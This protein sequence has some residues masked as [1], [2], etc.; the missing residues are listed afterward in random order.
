[1][2]QITSL[3]LFVTQ[4][5]MRRCPA[6][7]QQSYRPH[8]TLQIIRLARERP[9]RTRRGLRLQSDFLRTVLTRVGWYRVGQETPRVL[10]EWKLVLSLQRGIFPNFL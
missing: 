7:C 1:M 3:G 2:L 5:A 4:S 6:N 9:L 10:E 8:D